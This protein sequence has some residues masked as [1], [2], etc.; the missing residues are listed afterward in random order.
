MIEF[1]HLSCPKENF[2]RVWYASVLELDDH[3]QRSANFL[4]IV[5]N[6]NSLNLESNKDG[7]SNHVLPMK[8]VERAK[9]SM[10]GM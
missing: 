1:L 2:G 7:S 3:R 6:R 5:K 8:R 4:G 10:E 9:S